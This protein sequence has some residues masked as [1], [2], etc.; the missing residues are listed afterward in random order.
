MSQVTRAI[1]L[2]NDWTYGRGKASYVTG[3]KGV[4]QCILT[5]LQSFLGD[6][7]F[8]IEAGIDWFNLLGGKDIV[9]LELSIRAVILNTQYVVSLEQLRLIVNADRNLFLIYKVRTVFGGVLSKKLGVL[10]T[11]SGDILVTEDG[12]PIDA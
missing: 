12:D 4:A 2:N 9:A 8:D 7:F 6:C 11:E 3:L 10:L 5:R 1:D